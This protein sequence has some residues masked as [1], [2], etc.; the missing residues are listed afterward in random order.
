M[1]RHPWPYPTVITPL[2]HLNLLKYVGTCT[3]IL[4]YPLL[5]LL[6]LLLLFHY[7][8]TN[9]LQYRNNKLG[10][11]V[12]VRRRKPPPQLYI[13]IILRR[14]TSDLCSRL[15]FFLFST[16]AHNLRKKEKTKKKKR[17][18]TTTIK[19]DSYATRAVRIYKTFCRIRSPVFL[20]IQ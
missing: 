15:R 5:L 11:A 16:P 2:I 13:K 6:L 3:Y 10:R 9:G 19:F 4:K 17:Q 14:G 18:K 20:R 8:R 12:S 1:I 7:R